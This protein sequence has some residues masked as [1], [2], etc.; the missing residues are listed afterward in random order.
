[1]IFIWKH[2]I[3]P[4]EIR[5]NKYLQKKP[6]GIFFRRRLLLCR[7]VNVQLLSI[8]NKRTVLLFPTQLKV[9][10]GEYHSGKKY[11]CL[12]YSDELWAFHNYTMY[13]LPLIWHSKVVT[14]RGLLISFKQTVVSFMLSHTQ[15][16]WTQ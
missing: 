11:I 2:I 12:R 13:C 15:W 8:G 4:F 7:N 1:M 9:G 6:P 10:N 16:S 3:I 5:R 14:W